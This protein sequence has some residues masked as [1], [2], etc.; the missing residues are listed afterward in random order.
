MQPG[1]P[2][3]GGTAAADCQ[4]LTTLAATQVGRQEAAACAESVR[5]EYIIALV[6][7]TVPLNSLWLA[8]Q[9]SCQLKGHFGVLD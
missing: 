8:E 9:R 4:G 1:L 5:F 3:A 7:D 2:C 6:A